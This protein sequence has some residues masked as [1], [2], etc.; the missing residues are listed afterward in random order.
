MNHKLDTDMC[1]DLNQVQLANFFVQLLR[2][3]AIGA[4]VKQEGGLDV[5][6]D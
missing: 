6:Q 1:I 5:S 3:L 2:L 4:I